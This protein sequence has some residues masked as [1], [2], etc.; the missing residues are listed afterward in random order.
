MEVVCIT[1]WL[2]KAKIENGD[3]KW[4]NSTCWGRAQVVLCKICLELFRRRVN[5]MVFVA[6][7]AVENQALQIARR[8]E[9]AWINNLDGGLFGLHSDKDMRHPHLCVLPSST[10]N[11]SISSDC[12]IQDSCDFFL[13]ELQLVQ[14]AIVELAL[15]ADQWVLKQQHYLLGI[16]EETLYFLVENF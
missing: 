11:R 8:T 6:F 2:H 12:G 14:H 10:F 15:E 4:E 5:V 9:Q 13:I 3:S 16:T 7:R 1:A